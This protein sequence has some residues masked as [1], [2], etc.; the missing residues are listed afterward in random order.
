ML[1]ESVFYTVPLKA[2][3]FFFMNPASII[4]KQDLPC[5]DVY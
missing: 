2:Q 5:I 1:P 4:E 3:A